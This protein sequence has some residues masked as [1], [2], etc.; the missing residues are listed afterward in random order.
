MYLLYKTRPNIAFVIDQLS[1]QNENLYIGH[2]K[3]I[4]RVDYY[5][6]GTMYLKITYGIFL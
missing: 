4:K 6:K 1:R 3:T 2:F 5:F